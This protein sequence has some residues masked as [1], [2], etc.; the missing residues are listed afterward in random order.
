MPLYRSQSRRP[1]VP[2]AAVHLSKEILDRIER[3][4]E[5][6]QTSKHTYDAVQAQAAKQGPI[7]WATQPSPYRT[8]DSFPK[9]ALPAS[10]LDAPVGT[11]R[12][13]AE[14]LGAVP[15]SQLQPPQNLKTLATWLYLADGITIEKRAGSRKYS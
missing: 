7:D 3:V 8:Y 4:F 15:A 2:E 12:L 5:Y 13:L 11:L 9:V 6:H 1:V 14:G 10:I